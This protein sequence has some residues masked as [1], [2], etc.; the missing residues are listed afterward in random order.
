MS[1]AES[2]ETAKQV[3]LFTQILMWPVQLVCGGPEDNFDLD[4]I[5]EL[6]TK[7]GPWNEQENLLGRLPDTEPETSYAEFVYFQ[8]FV[9]RFLY[10][11]TK[12]GADDQRRRA[13]PLRLFSRPDIA[14]V[15]VERDSG[16][17]LLGVRRVCLYVFNVRIAVLVIEVEGH[18]LLFDD[19]VDLMDELRHVY[20]P[21]WQPRKSWHNQT[22]PDPFP[23]HCPLSVSWIGKDGTVLFPT[24]PNEAQSGAVFPSGQWG[25]G[26]EPARTTSHHSMV[27]FVNTHHRSPVD[28]AWT[29]ILSP[30]P[31]DTGDFSQPSLRFRQLQDERMHT[32]TYL[33]LNEPRALTRGD[34]VRLAF[35]DE[36]GNSLTLPYSTAFLENF[37]QR[38]CYDRFWDPDT[39]GHEWMTTRYLCCGFAFTLIGRFESG[40]FF[41]DPANGAL[42]HFRHHYQQIGLIVLFHRAAI[43]LF[44]DRLAELVHAESSSTPGMAHASSRYQQR[45]LEVQRELL[46][47]LDQYW[48]PEITSQIQG[49]ELFDWW[50][51]HLRTR[52]L[53]SQL[54]NEADR[55]IDLARAEQSQRLQ[56]TAN[57]ALPLVIGLTAMGAASSTIALWGDWCGWW[58]A[59]AL[60][61]ALFVAI[62]AGAATA[63]MLRSRRPST[64]RGSG[65]R[66]IAGSGHRSQMRRDHDR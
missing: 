64:E 61:L 24:P 35:N 12:V 66:V 5:A 10:G 36:R 18:D 7:D 48:F 49:R 44:N 22:L 32:M 20:P 41:A 15:Q 28:P 63:L 37:E 52:D 17:K 30:I 39:P 4:R 19:A 9:Q 3:R 55:V 34:F 65:V 45:V 25:P 11:T 6:L 8:P 56:Q 59:L 27:G 62:A 16:P 42:A 40:G 26:A 57:T 23:G 33:A 29:W 46:Q 31:Y 47:F 1:D 54:L 21:Y 60:T 50:S 43:L 14:K 51:S 2:T 13:S 53:C 38:Y 58:R